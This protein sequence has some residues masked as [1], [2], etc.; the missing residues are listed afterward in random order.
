M[1]R[2]FSKF[3]FLKIRNLPIIFG[4]L[5]KI[6]LS[7]NSVYKVTIYAIRN[8]RWMKKNIG[9]FD[10]KALKTYKMNFNGDFLGISNYSKY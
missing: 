2:Y 3:L 6:P 9:N 1:Y 10:I 4:K 5:V 7:K 8:F